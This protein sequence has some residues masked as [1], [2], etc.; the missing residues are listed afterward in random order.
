MP[1]RPKSVSWRPDWEILESREAPARLVVQ[2]EPTFTPSGSAV[3]SSSLTP[4]PSGYGAEWSTLAEVTPP[5]GAAGGTFHSGSFDWSGFLD[6]AIEPD[7]GETLGTPLTVF[8]SSSGLIRWD[9]DPK[10]AD[11]P[12]TNSIALRAT[13]TGETPW[14]NL[15]GGQTDPDN[16]SMTTE[17]QTGSGYTAVPA[18]I[19]DTIR[20]EV[21][22]TGQSDAWV[23]PPSNARGRVAA[24]LGIGA[25]LPP[26]LV[27]GPISWNRDGT[28]TLRYQ[29]RFRPIDPATD[30]SNSLIWLDD[31][32]MAVSEPIPVPLPQ[33]SPGS[34]EQRFALGPPPPGATKLQ[35]TLNADFLTDEQ[36][37]DNN[38]STVPFVAE[39]ALL[40][41]TFDGDSR[42]D[43][44]GR[45]FAGIPV[46]DQRYLLQIS[47]ELATF[48]RDPRQIFVRVGAV[49]LG[50]EPADTGP[51]WDGLTYRTRPHDPGRLLGDTH[52]SVQVRAG[53][54]I[55][56]E[57]SALL[58]IEPLPLWLRS[59]RSWALTF[60]P[61][62]ASYS[63]AGLLA[64]LS[65]SSLANP[66]RIWLGLPTVHRFNV[67]AQV[68]V[69]AS[70]DPSR[71]DLLTVNGT[72]RATGWYH[73]RPLF[74]LAGPLNSPPF[75]LQWN[76]DPR[77]LN[78]VH[79]QLQFQL[80]GQTAIPQLFDTSTRSWQR[81][82][83]TPQIEALVDYAATMSLDF[84]SNGAIQPVTS[85]LAFD[86]RGNL[87][88]ALDLRL[89]LGPTLATA[90]PRL[91]AL[92]KVPPSIVQQIREALAGSGQLPLLHIAAPISGQF[93]LS[94]TFRISGFGLTPVVVPTA[95]TGRLRLNPSVSYSLTWPG[96]SYTE[97]NA[98]WLQRLFEL[99]RT[100]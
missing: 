31:D 40:Q 87:S 6:W 97:P 81:F 24:S 41:A 43:V 67:W 44:V 5:S 88:G 18:H 7:P 85:S 1:S 68:Q 57:T 11:G 45:F 8:L 83:V 76:L 26:D 34:Y 96:G 54:R 100:P 35:F 77:T 60:D 75:S 69:N 12:T 73:G 21:Q 17:I 84:L 32:G 59:Q 61:G 49:P 20:I 72:G 86:Y 90:L 78:L 91:Q 15:S 3:I 10:T 92:L 39:V 38:S 50:V 37:F 4:F 29:I 13:R 2:S 16:S 65:A 89:P 19:G 64:H 98:V 82:L 58:D 30:F 95:R 46:P 55:L 62:T 9:L 66:G 93:D 42:P 27:A 52:L 80:V 53:G 23:L 63:F 48:V 28:V 14:F 79:G 22:A 47:P 51:G 99:D 70:I 36:D 71:S 33:R 94:R 56:A 25:Y 74:D